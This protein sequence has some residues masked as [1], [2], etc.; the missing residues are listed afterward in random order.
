MVPMRVLLAVLAALLFATLL[1][2][3]SGAFQSEGRGEIPA[4]MDNYVNDFAGLLPEAE[5]LELSRTLAAVESQTGIEIT[6]V[7]T[8]RLSTYGGMDAEALARRFFNVWGVGNRK[9]NDGILILVAT[10]DRRMAIEVGDGWGT[11]L[12][13]GLGDAIRNGFAPHFK[14]NR[15]PEGIVAGT[16]AVVNLVTRPREWY[17]K[18]WVQ[19]LAIMAA[20]L[21]CFAIGVNCIKE[22]RTGWGYAFLL[23][24]LALLV[25]LIQN[26]RS[27]GSSGSFGGGFSSGGGG[28]SGGW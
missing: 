9:S 22:G 4:A 14:K 28:A 25:F 19:N 8:R 21:L 27:R 3:P 26:N 15:F 12:K 7:T 20:M 11:R 2:P 6:V 13:S 18:K 23:A 16:L 24:A 5:R 10:E 17:E 1:P